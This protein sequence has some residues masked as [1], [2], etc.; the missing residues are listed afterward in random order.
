MIGTFDT[1]EENIAFQH[2]LDMGKQYVEM[3][4]QMKAETVLKKVK[5]LKKKK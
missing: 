1:I 5:K 2:H 4:F 3:F